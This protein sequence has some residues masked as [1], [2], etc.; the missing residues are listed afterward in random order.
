MEEIAVS[1]KEVTKVFK[2]PRERHASLKSMVV[3]FWRSARGYEM[4]Q[5]LSDISLEIKRGEFYGIIGRNGSG[6]STLLKLLAGI[7]DPTKGEVRVSGSLTPFIE[8]GV[9][10]NAELTGRENVYLNGAL[11]GF[12]RR[13]MQSMYDD[14]VKF[15]ELGRFMDQKLKNYSSGMQV[16]LA[17]S[18]AIR[19]ESDILLI[20]EVLAV[21]DLTFQEK[22]YNYF[23][24]VKQTGKTVVFVSHD[25]SAVQRF[26][27]K[28]AIIDK[29]KLVDVG[30]PL[31]MVL[32]YGA[33]IA[34]E[35]MSKTARA[36]QEKEKR[37]KGRLQILGA[38]I[39]GR[40]GQRTNSLNF[41]EEFTVEVNYKLNKPINEKVIVGIDLIDTEKNLSVLG[42]NT[43]EAHKSIKLERS[44]MVSVRFPFNPLSPKTYS[45]TVGFFNEGE[46]FAYDLIKD[47]LRFK[48]LG[49]SRH[50]AI[51]IE[52]V[53][54]VKQ[55][56]SGI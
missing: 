20:D 49:D 43:K 17:F 7:Y 41:G 56:K 48:V 2:L 50:G 16:R 37:V 28:T 54:S 29:G 52:P 45:L 15:A 27:D 1:V 12:S 39:V 46:T 3:N 25:S 42:P 8:L 35:Q 36:G 6:K 13:E 26:C 33:I 19:A 44:G 53:W 9:G 5:A 32:K 11:L 31:E 24:E 55:D 47:L 22:C 18:I 34:E 51:Y 10:F 38:A 23:E 40:D 21:G 30:D 14:I 4:Q